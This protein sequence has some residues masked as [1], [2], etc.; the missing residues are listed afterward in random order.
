M[1]TAPASGRENVAEIL[2]L[3][4]PP[5]SGKSTLA[6]SLKHTHVRVNQDLLKNKKACFNAASDHFLTLKKSQLP[7]NQPLGVVIDATNSNRAL[8]KEWIDFARAKD[9]VSQSRIFQIHIFI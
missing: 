9:V 8:R 6:R 7:A 4:G 1:Q 2:L 3:V 5:A